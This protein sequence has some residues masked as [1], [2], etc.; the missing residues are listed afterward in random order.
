MAARASRRHRPS[1]INALIQQANAVR[2]L[3]ERYHKLSKKLGIS[4]GSTIGQGK[5]RDRVALVAL[6]QKIDHPPLRD[7]CHAIEDSIGL[8][9]VRLQGLAFTLAAAPAKRPNEYLERPDLAPVRDILAT[10]IE[11][12]QGGITPK[13]L[14]AFRQRQRKAAPAQRKQRRTAAVIYQ[15]GSRSYSIDGSQPVTVSREEDNAL[16][17]FAKARASLDT[18]GLEK[19]GVSN[20]SRVMNQ[21]SKKFPGKIQKPGRGQKGKGYYVCVRPARKNVPTT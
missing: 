13:I 18:K 5:V 16:T 1:L 9:T 10:L 15:H 2:E 19:E 8:S 14:R 12:D 4:P 21:L 20:P 7:L 17:A 11:C 6:S 3:H